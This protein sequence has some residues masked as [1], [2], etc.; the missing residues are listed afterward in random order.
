MRA[1]LLSSASAVRRVQHVMPSAI[2]NAMSSLLVDLQREANRAALRKSPS[3]SPYD[4]LQPSMTPTTYLV[5]DR[6]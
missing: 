5:M 6:S 1:S 2:D 3:L 4:S